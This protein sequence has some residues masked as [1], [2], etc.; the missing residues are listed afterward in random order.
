MSTTYV[1]YKKEGILKDIHEGLTKKNIKISIDDLRSMCK[2]YVPKTKGKARITKSFIVDNYSDK[3]IVLFCAEETRAIS[4]KLSSFGKYNSFFKHK[5]VALPG[6]VFQKTRLNDV[7]AM[8]KMYKI[9]FYKIKRTDDFEDGTFI[10]ESDNDDGDNYDEGGEDEEDRDVAPKTNY[11]FGNKTSTKSALPTKTT[12][13]LVQKST[14]TSQKTV[15]PQKIT[16]TTLQKKTCSPQKNDNLNKSTT[17]TTV[18]KKVP[19]KSIQSKPT[20][21]KTTLKNT[22]NKSITSKNK[23]PKD[24][25]KRT[26][27]A[28]RSL[29]DAPVLK[30]NGWK[31]YWDEESKYVF[32]KLAIRGSKILRPVAIGRQNEE[33]DPSTKNTG[34]STVEA[35]STFDIVILDGAGWAYLTDDILIDLKKNNKEMYNKLCPLMYVNTDEDEDSDYVPSG[36]DDVEEEDEVMEEVEVDDVDEEIED[37]DDDAEDEGGEEDDDVDIDFEIEL[38]E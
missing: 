15:P 34:L 23:S 13:S 27:S 10:S 1:D 3:S 24:M 28:V 30:L 36:Q 7:M 33:N 18:I 16:A 25:P 22:L 32:Q 19:S 31:N 2:V 37:D 8:L 20:L 21:L 11:L 35:L 6:Y 17:T 12:T 26:S 4:A 9:P 29:G 14:A 38:D 5:D